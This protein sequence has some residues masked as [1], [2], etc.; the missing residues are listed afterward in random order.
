VCYVQQVTS[1]SL[2][3][4]HSLTL[5][6]VG[7]RTGSKHNQGRKKLELSSVY[8]GV[9]SKHGRLSRAQIPLVANE[10]F[11]ALDSLSLRIAQITPCCGNGSSFIYASPG[12]VPT[13]YNDRP[14]NGVS[15]WSEMP[16]ARGMRSVAAPK[17]TRCLVGTTRAQLLAL[18]H[19][20]LSIDTISG[21]VCDLGCCVISGLFTVHLQLPCVIGKVSSHRYT[22]TLKSVGTIQAEVARMHSYVKR[23]YLRPVLWIQVY[24]VTHYRYV[25]S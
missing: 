25:V 22:A 8:L 5:R 3:V 6:V 4:Y 24:C 16:F 18:L 17:V 23:R 13:A 1:R 7:H 20:K 10:A 9:H 19:F 15:E 14:V 21:P 11:P 12:T 2:D